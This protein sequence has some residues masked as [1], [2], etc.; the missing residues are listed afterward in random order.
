[1][2]VR[3]T[4]QKMLLTVLPFSVAGMAYLSAAPASSASWLPGS[5]SLGR[6]EA[7]LGAPKPLKSLAR[8]AGLTDSQND[9]FQLRAVGTGTLEVGGTRYLYTSFRVRNADQNGKAY[10]SSNTDLVFVAVGSWGTGAG[11]TIAGTAVSSITRADG[12]DY[13]DNPTLRKTLARAIQPTHAMVLDG[14]RLVPIP[15]ASDFVAFTEAEIDPANFS[16]P[17]NLKDLEASTV[18]PYGFAV[19]CV[20]NCTKGPRTLATNPA[21]DQFDGAVTIA[22]KLPAQTNP[23]DNPVAFSLKLEVLGNNPARVTISPEEGLDLGPALARAQATGAPSI[24]AIGSGQRTVNVEQYRALARTPSFRAPELRGV[25]NI[26][27]ANPDPN[28]APSDPPSFARAAYLL[29]QP[30][31]LPTFVLPSTAP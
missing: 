3:K 2:S 31:S 5:H 14:G 26:R 10:T 22:V 12:S 23:K 24:L 13:A 9:G 19:R 25:A 6:L 30:Q 28:P 16:P 20:S 1:M 29:P 18:F 4:F 21:P 11:D 7:H 8:S 27:T 17:T 15:G